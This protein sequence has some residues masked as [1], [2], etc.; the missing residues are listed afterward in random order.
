MDKYIECCADQ[1]RIA[2][3]TWLHRVSQAAESV[4]K[5]SEQLEVMQ[6]HL[7]FLNEFVDRILPLHLLP[8]QREYDVFRHKLDPRLCAHRLD[9]LLMVL[10]H[11]WEATST[12]RTTW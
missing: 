12:A 10:D 1:R 5:H 3:K 7:F 8:R 2:R 6:K 4:S 9:R 11:A